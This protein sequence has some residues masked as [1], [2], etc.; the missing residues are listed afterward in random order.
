MRDRG[1]LIFALHDPPQAW[2]AQRRG[3]PNLRSRACEVAVRLQG[4]G[5]LRAIIPLCGPFADPVVTRRLM[6][7]DLAPQMWE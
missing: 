1:A 5:R 4:A 6:Y 3:N 2:P 7:I